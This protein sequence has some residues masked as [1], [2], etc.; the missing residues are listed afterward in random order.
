LKDVQKE[1]LNKK[2]LENITEALV[3]IKIL[4]KTKSNLPG[5]INPGRAMFQNPPTPIQSEDFT[6]KCS[7][8]KLETDGKSATMECEVIYKSHLGIGGGGRK[9]KKK[10]KGRRKKRSN[11]KKK[12]KK[13]KK[14]KK[15]K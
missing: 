13:K 6:I 9:S 5:L 7:N 15:K 12:T 4:E 11:K 2:Q 8:Y 14:K 3:H 10:P 1:K